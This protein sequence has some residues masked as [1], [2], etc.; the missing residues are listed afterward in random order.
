MYFWIC[1]FFWIV[2]YGGFNWISKFWIWFVKLWLWDLSWGWVL[3]LRVFDIGGMDLV[4]LYILDRFVSGVYIR[5]NFFIFI[6]FIN[7]FII[8]VNYWFVDINNWNKLLLI[9]CYCKYN[10][11]LEWFGYFILYVDIICRL[12]YLIF[13]FYF[14]LFYVYKSFF[15]SFL[16]MKVLSSFLC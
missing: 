12:R 2:Y 10:L 9:F 8:F 7:I 11:V 5:V 6:W 13:I 14:F 16:Y 15:V 3:E 1:L 4:L